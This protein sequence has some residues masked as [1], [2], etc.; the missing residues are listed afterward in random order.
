M[1]GVARRFVLTLVCGGIV[2]TLASPAQ[3]AFPGHNGRIL[4]TQDDEEFRHQLFDMWPDGTDPRN[5]GNSAVQDSKASYSPDGRLIVFAR[6]PVG[7]GDEVNKQSE[8]WVMDAD[9]SHQRRLTFNQRPDYDAAWSPDSKRLVFAR[10]PGRA[11]AGE[12]LG[13][14]DLWT[15]DL[16]TGEE[17][18][19]T[20]SPR[21][22]DD[23]PQWSPDGGRIVFNSDV[24]APGNVDVYTIRPDGRD[25][26]RITTTL[27]SDAFPNYSPDGERITFTSDRTG[28]DDVFV[29]R[30]DGSRQ[31]Q[32]THN[33][34]T[35]T[36]SAFSPDGQF[37][38]YTSAR[39]G[40]P[41][42]DGGF[43]WDIF[44]M[45][46]DGSQQT[47]LTRSPSVDNYDP[48]WQPL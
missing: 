40:D 10:R 9:G 21:I 31:T 18:H 2:F 47:N 3:A 11:P 28:N 12:P 48:D 37:I 19:L 34:T 17:R 29:M 36:L 30:A 14:A 22:D 32:L 23:R 27:S 41:F 6:M 39:D 20:N 25:L 42:P 1:H 35:D 4:F 33:R 45:R 15:L 24:N 38:S 46:A 13:P 26:R 7:F 43:Y 44:R 8:L 16:R 5:L